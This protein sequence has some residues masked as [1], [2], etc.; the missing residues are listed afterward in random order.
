MTESI[1]GE[2]MKRSVFLD[3]PDYR[4]E[5][6]TTTRKFGV[7]IPKLN[8]QVNDLIERHEQKLQAREAKLRAMK[9]GGAQNGNIFQ[10]ENVRGFQG[11][12]GGLQNSFANSIRSNGCEQCNP[13]MFPNINNGQW[14]GQDQQYGQQHDPQHSCCCKN[15]FRRI[16]HRS[17]SRPDSAYS[18][19]TNTMKSQL[20]GH[21]YG[22]YMNEPYAAV[23]SNMAGSRFYKDHPEIVPQLQS[24]LLGRPCTKHP[25]F[26]EGLLNDPR[27]GQKIGQRSV[28][29]V[30]S[31]LLKESSNVKKNQ[32]LQEGIMKLKESGCLTVPCQRIRSTNDATTKRL[33]ATKAIGRV[34]KQPNT[35]DNVYA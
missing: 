8:D 26:E 35:P 32:A 30:I 34:S 24:G 28:N 17:E 12:P 4:D 18:R 15:K 22:Y 21:K 19:D 31:T 14:D 11:Q 16:L 5:A 9:N 3:Y 20:H 2:K 10:T 6:F 27:T 13:G 25:N 1:V 7:Y 33:N 29:P 23:G